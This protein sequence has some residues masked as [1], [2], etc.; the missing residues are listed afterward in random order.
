MPSRSF[1]ARPGRLNGSTST[2]GGD[3]REDVAKKDAAR[4]G[5]LLGGKLLALTGTRCI[6]DEQECVSHWRLLSP[7]ITASPSCSALS[8]RNEIFSVARESVDSIMC[9]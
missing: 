3:F 6:I 8:G 2:V 4:I 5:I 1:T 9:T 7:S